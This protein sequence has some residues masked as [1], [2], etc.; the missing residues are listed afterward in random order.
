MSKIL[1]PVGN[2]IGYELRPLYFSA[3]YD[4]DDVLD[5][6]YRIKGDKVIVKIQINPFL[7]KRFFDKDS[8][9][10]SD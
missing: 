2:V 7:Q 8:F 5:V 9:D 3:A 1:D 4:S 10:K 6:D